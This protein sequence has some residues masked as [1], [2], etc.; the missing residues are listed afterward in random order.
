MFMFD[1]R[2]GV[3]PMIGDWIFHNSGWVIVALLSALALV[4]GF[5]IYDDATSD[6][7]SLRKDEWAC[8]ALHYSPVTTTIIV[9][10][11][12]IPQTTLRLVCDRWDRIK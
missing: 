3:R 9:G 2:E 12:I 11:V 4:I 7:F 5:A 6:K 8:G 1:E 10:K